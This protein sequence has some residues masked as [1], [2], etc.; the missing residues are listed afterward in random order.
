MADMSGGTAAGQVPG[1]G[2]DRLPSGLA[3]SHDA[4]L[5]HFRPI[6]TAHGLTASQWRV[7]RVLSTVGELDAGETARRALLQP[8][9]LSRLLRQLNERGLIATWTPENDARRS[10]HA[11]TAAGRDLVFEIE[12]QLTDIWREIERRFGVQRLG[13]LAEMLDAFSD[14]IER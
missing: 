14:A 4:L 9:G 10:M 11:L 7:L 13:A 5:D 8:S 12:S 3:R 1:H 6:F 2:I